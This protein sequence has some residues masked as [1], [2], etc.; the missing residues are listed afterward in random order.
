MYVLGE[1][2]T[3]GPGESDGRR[4]IVREL[5]PILPR[6]CP[7]GPP[8]RWVSATNADV[9]RDQTVG[10]YRALLSLPVG[11]QAHEMHNGNFWKFRVVSRATDPDLTS[12]AKDVR[13]WICQPSPRVAALNRGRLLAGRGMFASGG[14]PPPP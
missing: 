13:G 7:S 2:E 5:G 3:V 1:A 8:C 12:F 11:T 10:R 9:A 6:V 4:G 14:G